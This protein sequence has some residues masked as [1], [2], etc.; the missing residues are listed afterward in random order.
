M[1]K[2]NDEIEELTEAS[3]QNPSHQF[4]PR[5]V[6]LLEHIGKMIA[7]EMIAEASK[8]GQSESDESE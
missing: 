7:K 4:D 3:H 2:F 1:T 5:F 8:K 6:A